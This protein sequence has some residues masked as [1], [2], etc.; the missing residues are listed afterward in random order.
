MEKN[1]IF[2]PYLNVT[3]VISRNLPCRDPLLKIVDSCNRSQI[4]IYCTIYSMGGSRICGKGFRCV[5][6]GGG[7]FALLILSHFS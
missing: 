4:C 2:R 7:G 1:T 6:E 3:S 5:K